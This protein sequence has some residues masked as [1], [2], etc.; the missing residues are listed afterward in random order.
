M[1]DPKE[2]GNLNPEGDL[3]PE[4]PEFPTLPEFERPDLAAAPRR[5]R[6]VH[7]LLAYG[8]SLPERIIRWI[9]SII[10]SCLLVLTFLLPRQIREGRF[11]KTTVRRQI[12]MLVD[13]VG[14]AGVFQGEDEL[15]T[16]TAARLGVG[17]AVDNLLVLTMHASPI[18]LLLAATDVCKGAA[19]FVGEIGQELKDAGVMR[20]GSRL[21]SGDDVLEG[22][23]RLSER[24]A[25]TVDMPPITLSEMKETVLNL[26]DEVGGVTG[27]VIDTADLEGFVSDVRNAATGANRSLLQ[28]TAAIATGALERTGNVVVG[29]AVGTTATIRY[30][31]R[32]VGDVFSDYAKSLNTIRRLGFSGSLRRFLKPQTRSSQRLFA[33]S[34]L[35]FTEIG[36]SLGG[37]RKTAWRT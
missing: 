33:Y 7:H 13:D 26:K 28:T 1:V 10:G 12:K 23:S 21:D 9:A 31:G 8:L 24:M 11:Y 2:E 15:D 36:L 4:Q 37:W 14:Q 19:G 16:R 32:N 22:L 30:V 18:W 35:T 20:E 5:P 3:N 25:D 27:T 17:G 34:F 6:R 29:T